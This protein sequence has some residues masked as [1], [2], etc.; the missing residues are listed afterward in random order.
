MFE[1]ATG[2]KEADIPVSADVKSEELVDVCPNCGALFSQPEGRG[3]PKKFC[4]EKC[5]TAWHH[6]HPNPANWKDTSRIAVCPM[7][8]KEF[9]ATREYGRLRKY[10]SRACANR[11]RANRG[12][13][14]EAAE[15]KEEHEEQ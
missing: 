6:R 8:G 11:G 5:R 10:C 2:A 7:C 1:E 13:A 9:T 4:S 12:R 3:H 15:R 14:I